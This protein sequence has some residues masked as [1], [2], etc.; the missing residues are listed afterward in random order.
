MRTRDHRF[1]CE[2]PVDVYLPDGEAWAV[3]HDVAIGGAGLSGVR[4]MRSGQG[5]TLVLEGRRM[6]ATVAWVDGDEFGVKFQR[7]LLPSEFD[8]I[9]GVDAYAQVTGRQSRRSSG[10]RAA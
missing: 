10:S 8:L 1:F 5:C 3:I 4:G 6:P 9:A 2:F 7:R